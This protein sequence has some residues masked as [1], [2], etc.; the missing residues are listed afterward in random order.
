MCP[1]RSVHHVPGKHRNIAQGGA[2][3]GTLGRIG[4][5]E[6]RPATPGDASARRHSFSWRYYES[7]GFIETDSPRFFQPAGRSQRG[8]RRGFDR[9]VSASGVVSSGG[10]SKRTPRYGRSRSIIFHVNRGNARN[11]LRLRKGPLRP[12]TRT[13]NSARWRP[14]P[15]KASSCAAETALRSSTSPT[16]GRVSAPMS[17]SPMTR[18]HNR[19]LFLI[20]PR[21]PLAVSSQNLQSAPGRGAISR[22]QSRVDVVERRKV[23]TDGFPLAS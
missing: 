11:S 5:Q 12:R 17:R 19:R 4:R 3:G 20:E 2:R 9:R 10:V 14:S 7:R 18:K 21:K 8:E 6:D 15:G 16:A 22:S 1:V 23:P 13:I